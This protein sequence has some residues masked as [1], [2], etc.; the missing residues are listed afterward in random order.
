MVNDYV[1]VPGQPGDR[2]TMARPSVPYTSERR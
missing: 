2:T 1:E